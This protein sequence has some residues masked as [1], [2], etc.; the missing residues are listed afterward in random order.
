[1]QLQ[2]WVL[3]KGAALKKK[4]ETRLYY[5]N[6]GVTRIKLLTLIGPLFKSNKYQC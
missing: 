4:Y 1:M 3:G 2:I 5:L 6:G